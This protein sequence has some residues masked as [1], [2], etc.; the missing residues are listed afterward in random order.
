MLGEVSV[1]FAADG[2]DPYE[3]IHDGG[4]KFKP[5]IS[6]TAKQKYRAAYEVRDV[7]GTT[8]LLGPH[9]DL[10]NKSTL[11]RVYFAIDLDARRIVVGHIGDHLPD[12][13]N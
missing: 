6:D 9:L 4:F 5:D 7:D 3:A 12:K 1:G 10:G 11:L 2:I 13:S 8:L